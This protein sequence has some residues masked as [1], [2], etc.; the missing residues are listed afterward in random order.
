LS[1]K[2]NAGSDATGPARPRDQWS[3]QE[4]RRTFSL[5]VSATLLY[6][7]YGVVLTSFPAILI[8]QQGAPDWLVSLVIAA[9]SIGSFSAIFWSRYTEQM[10]KMKVMLLGGGLARLSIMLT[11]FAFNPLIFALILV[12]CNVLENSKSPAYAAIMQQVY[13]THRRGELMARVR[14][15]TSIATIIASML[16]GQILQAFDYRWVYPVAGIFGVG[17]ILVFT[18]I[19]Y[20]GV[21]S[22]RPPTS[23]KRMLLI[24]RTDKNYGAFLSSTF[25]VGFAN[26]MALSIYPLIA[27]DELHVTSSFYGIMGAVTSGVAIVFYFIWGAYSDHHH[28]IV[29]TFITFAIALI[30][31][32]VYLI[33]WNPLLLLI[34]A[35]VS[36]IANSGGDLATINNAIRF[37]KE[38][39]DIPHYMALYTSLIGVRGVIA[40]FLVSFLLLFLSKK[41]VLGITFILMIIGVI[42]FYVVMRRLLRDPDFADPLQTPSLEKRRLF[43]FGRRNS[44]A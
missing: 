12:V 15:A 14:V 36:G 27:V 34:P 31:F 30:T 42:N 37:P 13:P 32:L 8:R 23:L 19:H 33:A 38:R 16:M 17:S 21:P 26:W 3:R 29:I 5:D 39:E 28:P 20:Y 10:P 43:P 1:E 4:V 18:R 35:V 9:P 41:L 11:L 7:V 22:K 25:L 24:P 6:S 40:P 2:D 44:S